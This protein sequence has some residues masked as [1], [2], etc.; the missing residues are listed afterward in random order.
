MY[1]I[2]AGELHQIAASTALTLE[3]RA[4]PSP[5]STPPQATTTHYNMRQGRG[6]IHLPRRRAEGHLADLR[7]PD[8]AP[9]ASMGVHLMDGVDS[10][11]G[12]FAL[13]SYLRPDRTSEGRS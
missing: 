10:S 1:W 5:T 2:N 9:E 8:A 4:A 13:T 6:S 3:N 7:E 12:S 11:R